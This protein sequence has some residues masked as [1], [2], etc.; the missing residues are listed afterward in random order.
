[1]FPAVPAPLAIAAGFELFPKVSP[2]L[3]I[4]DH[5]RRQG[6]WVRA[7]DIGGGDLHA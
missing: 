5:D 2:V 6:G 3:R 7:L 4:W 1:V